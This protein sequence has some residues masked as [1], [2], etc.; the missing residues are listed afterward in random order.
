MDLSTLNSEQYQAVTAEHGPLLVL[1]GAGSGKTRALT[2]RIAHLISQRQVYPSK[3]LALTFTNK[4]ASEMKERL[5]ELVG[6]EASSIWMGTFHSVAIRILRSHFTELGMSRDFVIYDATDQRTLVSQVL[7]ELNFNTEKYPAKMVRSL[8]SQAKS[9]I[10]K[11]SDYK[12]HLDEFFHPVFERYEQR[13]KAAEAM[14]FDNILLHLARLFDQND[15]LRR[16]Y[17][18]KFHEVLVDEYQDTNRVQYH[19]VHQLTRD[20]GNLVVVGDVDQ[21]I[22][23]WR[24]ADIRNILEFQKDF[25][26]ARVIKLEQNYRSTNHILQLANAVIENNK[27]RPAKKL[28]TDQGDGEKVV[29]YHAESDQEEAEYIV[30]DITRRMQA[31]TP[32]KDIAILYR[33]HAQSRLL[34]ERLRYWGHAYQIV[35]GVKFYD[36]KEIKDVIA[37]LRVLVNPKDDIS[38]QR[39]ISVPRRGLGDK[40]MEDLGRIARGE[41]LS[42][43]EAAVYG[44]ENELFATRYHNAL[45]PFI[46]LFETLRSESDTADA[47]ELTR[48]ILIDSGYQK[49]LEDSK[50]LEDA[51]RLENIGE[52]L[53]DV[54]AYSQKENGSLEEYLID[55]SLLAEVDEMEDQPAV[56]LMTL[57]SSKG[58][59]YPFVYLCGMDDNIFP[60]FLSKEADDG[61]EE[62]RRLCYVGFTRAMEQLVLTRADRRFRFG[63]SQ[64]M[65]PSPFLD[66]I[67]LERVEVIGA[68]K[69]SAFNTTIPF[70]K[71]PTPTAGGE[72]QAGMHVTHPKFG[73]GIIASYDTSSKVLKIVF[74]NGEIK[75]LHSDYAPLSIV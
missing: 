53:N 33:T 62:E 46:Q 27:N 8:I 1:A 21:S 11:L 59:E 31:G 5:H 6:P 35:G 18:D 28:W 26:G 15:S 54:L 29:L 37:Y 42:L 16:Y 74:D 68:P 41:E 10:T 56:T 64:Y 48:R 72:F 13:M 67:P 61:L 58:L 36:R 44:L 14:D 50:Q 4:A 52:L 60:S 66:E 22:Y 69:K 40:F 51:S 20:K 34:E 38:F 3:I 71:I 49:M 43:Y 12:E 7:K 9:Q 47:Y 65:T 32:L 45:A 75:Q 55:I 39:I 63:Q 30:Q 2:F 24:G 25:P 57:H 17:S 23:G 70:L 73:K 19:I